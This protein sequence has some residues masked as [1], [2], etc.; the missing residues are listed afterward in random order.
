MDNIKNIF[1][2]TS[3]YVG[4]VIG[5]GFAS[6]Q[7]M[8]NFFAIYGFDGIYGLILT[9]FLFFIVG[10]AV[11][12]LIYIKKVKTFR[13]FINPI[14]GDF[15]GGMLEWAIVGFMFACFCVMLAGGGALIEQK[16]SLP[17]E[18]GVLLMAIC[19]LGTFVFGAKG[20]VAINAILA[21]IL[22]IGSL[23]LGLYILVFKSSEAF[24]SLSVVL[25]DVRNN[26][27]TSAII[28]ISYNLITA[29]VVLTNLNQYIK[30]KKIAFY[31]SLISG[32]SLGILGIFLGIITIINYNNI[33]G[34]EIPMLTIVMMYAPSI[35][36]IYIGIILTA[37]F[38]TAVANGYG[39]LTKL[40]PGK[41]KN[42]LT[43]VTFISVSFLFA[44]IGFSTMVHNI[45]PLFGYIGLFELILIVI[46]FVKYKAKK[47][48]G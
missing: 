43:M 10:W 15:I 5:A 37:M 17:Y 13:D 8:L 45:Y 28:Y 38:T 20:V 3:V 35:Q 34:I 36:Y 26:W 7:E 46:Y 42:Y 22:L 30:N 4:T 25:Y 11:M 2:I 44:Q 39:V 27:F 23:L 29:I 14:T 31:S 24:Q 48:K 33:Q 32:M 41:K 12:E 18:W 1:K 40:N 6:G 19:C 21:P 9:G 47:M 16:F